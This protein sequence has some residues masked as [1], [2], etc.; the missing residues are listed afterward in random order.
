[1]ADSAGVGEPPPLWLPLGEG[2]PL[3]GEPDG[4]CDA[5]SEG[6]PEPEGEGELEGEG[7]PDPGEGEADWGEGEPDCGGGEPDCGGGLPVPPVGGGGDCGGWFWKI[8]M[9]IRMASAASSSISNQETKMVSH[10]ARS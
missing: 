2:E 4:D 8:R 3:V 6:E 1:M 10:P 5:D 7:E 9:A